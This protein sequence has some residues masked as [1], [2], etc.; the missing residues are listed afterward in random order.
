MYS[1]HDEWD[2]SVLLIHSVPYSAYHIA[3]TV[4]IFNSTKYKPPLA[5]GQDDGDDVL[6]CRWED[7]QP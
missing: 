3:R 5:A 7:G 4:Y 6:G 1:V 2:R